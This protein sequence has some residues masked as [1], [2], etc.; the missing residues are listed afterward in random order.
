[1]KHIGRYILIGVIAAAPAAALG[2]Y[3]M[4]LMGAT[5]LAANTLL[6][7]RLGQVFRV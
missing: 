3:G 7:K 4:I 1:M 2:V 5:L 6:G